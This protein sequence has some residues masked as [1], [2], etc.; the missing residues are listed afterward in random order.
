MGYISAGYGQDSRVTS[1]LAWM[2]WMSTMIVI[3]MVA[4]S[5]GSYAAN[6]A[7]QAGKGR[8]GAARRH[9]ILSRG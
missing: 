5:F 9:L 4:V 7:D 1:S 8:G 6:G 2:V 3:S